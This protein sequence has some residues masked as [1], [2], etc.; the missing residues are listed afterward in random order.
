VLALWRDLGRSGKA[1]ADGLA[2]VSTRLERMSAAAEGPGEVTARAE[3]SVARLQVSL[4]RLAVLRAAVSDVR[5]S[6]GR[7]TAVYPRK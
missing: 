3:P 4:A 5:D 2:A 6:V 7:V 1:L